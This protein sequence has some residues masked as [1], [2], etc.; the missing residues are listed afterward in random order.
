MIKILLLTDL[1]SQYSRSLL[2]GIMR[3][4][5]EQ[6]NWV[7]Q[8]MP[9][10]YRMLNGEKGVVAWA[11]EWKADAVI[12]QL[13]DV[14][15]E[16]L[17]NLSIP[18]IVQNYSDR[19]P[20]V[21]NLTGDYF[22][23]GVMAADFFIQKGYSNFAFYGF[24][25]SVWSRERRDGFIS[26]LKHNGFK[27][28]VKTNASDD[29]DKW[30]KDHEA[31]A[32]W[33]QMLP[34]PLALFAC[35]DLYALHVTEACNMFNISVPEEVAVLGVD[36]DELLCNIS[37][38]PLSSI[39]LN[40]E[41]GGY[42][43]GHLIHQLI[44]KEITEPFNIV[45]P[46]LMIVRRTSTDRYA[47]DDKY[48]RSVLEFIDKN[49]TRHILVDEL[50]SLVPLSRRVLEKRFKKEIHQSIHQYIMDLRLEYFKHLL[51]TSD[52]KMY[53]MA[54]KSGLSDCKNLSRFFKKRFDQ[55]P[56]QYRKT[57]GKID[58]IGESNAAK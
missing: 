18:I 41:Q 24:N 33:L 26:Q 50:V 4:S 36:N 19:N 38:P 1:T 20:L 31:I 47:V 55:S 58:A 48:I 54:I 9:M 57:F 46:P 35:D 17:N 45:V 43:A 7:F 32:K 22:K 34:K 25:G 30:N 27:T 56:A 5:K 37:N 49:F 28:F 11:K 53:D 3:Y 29:S 2:K 39:L 16:M 10:Y 21:S 12:A 23:T 42:E 51:L 6:G 8:R 40:A 52:E 44:N 14:N 13:S 15:I